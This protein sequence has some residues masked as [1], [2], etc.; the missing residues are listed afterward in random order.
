MVLEYISFLFRRKVSILH[1]RIHSAICN[2][3]TGIKIAVCI[4]HKNFSLHPSPNGRFGSNTPT[5]N[6]T[7][8]GEINLVS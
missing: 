3:N 4:L 8:T 1:P 5:G 2:M 6:N 7:N